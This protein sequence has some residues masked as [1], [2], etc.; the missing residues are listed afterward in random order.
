VIGERD[1]AATEEEPGP[2][3]RRLAVPYERD[4]GDAG[5]R[6]RPDRRKSSRRPRS[7]RPKR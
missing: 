7:A 6:R 5:A 4:H 2:V 3:R 1:V